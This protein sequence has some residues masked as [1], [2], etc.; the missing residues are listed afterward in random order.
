MIGLPGTLSFN[1]VGNILLKYEESAFPGAAW[2]N[3][4][5]TAQNQAFNWKASGGLTYAGAK[6][7]IGLRMQYLPYLNPL[8]TAVAGTKGADAHTQFDLFARYQVNDLLEVRGGIDNLFNAQPEIFGA[9]PGNNNGLGTLP[10][11]D[12]IGR[13]F[14]IGAK[15]RM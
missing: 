2:I 7:S 11:Y 3:Y 9:T 6:G 8:P 13:A 1:A 15:L 10:V 4:K 12:Q 14:Y 5:G